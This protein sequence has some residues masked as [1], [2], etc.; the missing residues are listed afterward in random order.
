MAVDSVPGELLITAFE[1]LT[2]P[3]ELYA[4]LAE[5]LVGGVLLFDANLR[6]AAQIR[7]LIRALRAAAPGPLLVTIDHEGGRV[8]RLRHVLGERPSASVLGRAAMRG[9]LQAVATAGAR[10]ASELADLGIHLNLAPVV[11]VRTTHDNPALETRMFGDD[12]ELVAACAEAYLNGLQASGTVAGC[13]KHF[14][15]LGGITR[16]PHQ[17]MPT[18]DRSRDELERLDLVPFRTLLRRKVAPAVMV[19]HVLVSALDATLPATLSPPIVTGL[20]RRELAFDGVIVADSLA[21]AAIAKRYSIG[22]ACVLAARAGCDLLLGI[23]S[24]AQARAAHM[25]LRVA[26]DNGTLEPV[27][28]TASLARIRALKAWLRLG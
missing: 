1:G 23:T 24:P 11:D 14:P 17:E 22:R 2:V 28:M 10:D 8:N 26:L 7:D 15:G 20:L 4:V 12:P 9:D 3:S 16:D 25:A 18:I 21:M 27:R 13:L 19:S 6:D 5:G